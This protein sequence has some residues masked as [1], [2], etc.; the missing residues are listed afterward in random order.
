MSQAS[1]KNPTPFSTPQAM[2]FLS[3]LKKAAKGQREEEAV[4]DVDVVFVPDMFKE[5]E[6]PSTYS[7]TV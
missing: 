7:Q 2:Q 6:I 5:V 4:T 1:A 3:D